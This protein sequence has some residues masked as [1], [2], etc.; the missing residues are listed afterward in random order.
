VNPPFGFEA[1]ARLILQYL[2][3]VLARDEAGRQRV[4]WLAAE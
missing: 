2:Q 4:A 1:E 3:K